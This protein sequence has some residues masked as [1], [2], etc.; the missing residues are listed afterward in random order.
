MKHRGG[1]RPAGRQPPSAEP[2]GLKRAQV[3]RIE[4]GI[5]RYRRARKAGRRNCRDN[6]LGSQAGRRWGLVIKGPIW[7]RVRKQLAKTWSGLFTHGVVEI[8]RPVTV[9][10]WSGR[11]PR[12]R[13]GCGGALAAA[14]W[15]SQPDRAPKPHAHSH[16]SRDA[17]AREPGLGPGPQPGCRCSCTRKRTTPAGAARRLLT[18]A[19]EP[20]HL[21]FNLPLPPDATSALLAS[22]RWKHRRVHALVRVLPFLTLAAPSLST[23]PP[24]PTLYA[25]VTVQLWPASQPAAAVVGS[26]TRAAQPA[27]RQRRAD[28]QNPLC[29]RYSKLCCL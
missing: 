1:R 4:R 18:S 15:P 25:A 23:S 27:S 17:L 10:R 22:H 29:E 3:L 21:I 19:A 14:H 24:P 12:S 20:R 13:L 9:S 2:L 26:A 5:D 16:L 7:E 28:F 8:S 11:P 6:A